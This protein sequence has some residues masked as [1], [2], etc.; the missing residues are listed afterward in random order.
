MVMFFCLY[1]CKQGDGSCQLTCS[2]PEGGGKE[3]GLFLII[4]GNKE[5]KSL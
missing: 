2:K 4:G 3:R 1:T 5:N